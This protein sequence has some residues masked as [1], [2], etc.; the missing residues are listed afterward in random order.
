MPYHTRP[1]A[2]IP[3]GCRSAYLN[4][5]GQSV[6]NPTHSTNADQ[7]EAILAIPRGYLK[8]RPEY[9]RAHELC[10]DCGGVVAAG[11]G[12]QSVERIEWKSKN[13]ASAERLF[14]GADDS[15][16]K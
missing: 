1:K 4:D 7:I 9:L 13:T 2:P 15:G 3:T 6:S 14:D 10:H 8:R 12:R 11:A 5:E 16:K